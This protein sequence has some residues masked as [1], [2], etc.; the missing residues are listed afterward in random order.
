ML[1]IWIGVI[2]Y[3]LLLVVLASV[4]PSVELVEMQVKRLEGN[5]GETKEET[6]AKFCSVAPR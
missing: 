6:L 1:G 4:F 5:E 3:W 2:G